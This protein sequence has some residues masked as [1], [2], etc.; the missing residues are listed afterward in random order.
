MAESVIVLTTG[1][2]GSGKSYSRVHWLV[3]DFLINNIG[4]YITNLPLKVDDIADYVS[5]KLGCDSEDVKKRIVVIPKV[6]LDKWYALQHEKKVDLDAMRECNA[7]PPSEYFEQ[8]DLTNAHICIDEFHLYFSKNHPPILRELWSIWF[9]EI[10][11]L[12]CTFEA[13]TQDMSLIPREFIGKV[14]RRID[15]I[16]VS[17]TRDPFFG[18]LM[19]DWYELRAGLLG[20]CEQKISQTEYRK[21]TSFT[22]SVKW[23]ESSTKKFVISPD[24]YR[25]YN[26]YQRNDNEKIGKVITP[27]ERYGK[28]IVF[29]FLRRNFF[30][31]FT[32]FLLVLLFFWLCFGGGMTFLINKF[33]STT[34]YIAKSNGMKKNPVSTE[35]EKKSSPG[36]GSGDKKSSAPSRGIPVPRRQ[37]RGNVHQRS[38]SVEHASDA[39]YEKSLHQYKPTMFYENS[40]WLRNGIK[41]N[42]GYKFKGGPYHGKTVQ[43]I[44]S[45]DRCYYLS[46]GSCVLMY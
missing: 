35:P 26:S 22:G 5:G 7:F 13:V 40:C 19:G 31:L 21:G 41:I 17:T 16:P 30:R 23:V 25:F 44:E 12:G 33:I 6:E 38:Q 1:Q 2:P 27:A 34:Q 4:L 3:T 43:K 9:A 36:Q 39:D 24:F 29:W 18:I 8:F 45:L 46:D 37:V 28:L 20:V 11:K 14:G 32:R 15:L 42:V 10:R